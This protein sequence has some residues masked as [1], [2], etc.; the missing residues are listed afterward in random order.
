MVN[1]GMLLLIS[2]STALLFEVDAPGQY[3][4]SKKAAQRMENKIA[5]SVGVVRK[6]SLTLKISGN[7][8]FKR[9]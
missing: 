6:W 5:Q 4:I 3:N 1:Y 2:N 9:T 8:A 7:L